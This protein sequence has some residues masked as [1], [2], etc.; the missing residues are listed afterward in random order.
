[1]LSSLRRVGDGVEARLFN[2][3]DQAAGFSLRLAPPGSA[4][5]DTAQRVNSESEPLEEPFPLGDGT[6]EATLQPK[7]FETFRFGFPA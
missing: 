3:G 1:M 2:P 6:L 5:P 4:A 7:S